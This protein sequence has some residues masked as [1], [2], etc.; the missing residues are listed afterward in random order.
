MKE[1]LTH[2]VIITPRLMAGVAVPDGY[3]SVAPAG[4]VGEYGKP[5]WTYAIDVSGWD[6]EGSDLY[7]WGDSR[8]MLGTLVS[9]LC[10]AAES[11]A[12]RMSTGRAG[13]SEDLFPPRVVEWA[14]A[15]SDELSMLALEIEEG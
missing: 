10:A 4:D 15:N 8:A 9:F 6:E 5:R 11:Y 1:T 14:Y 3:L 7:G 2:P 12:Y 13:E